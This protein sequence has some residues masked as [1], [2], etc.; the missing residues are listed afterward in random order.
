MA[1]PSKLKHRAEWAS[2][3]SAKLNADAPGS[4]R[5]VWAKRE[6]DNLQS[7]IAHLGS[8]DGG[9]WV[10]INGHH[11]FMRDGGGGTI[12]APK[13][14]ATAG[15]KKGDLVRFANPQDPAEA[16][17]VYVL[18]ELHADANPP[19][20]T[21]QW[22][23]PMSKGSRFNPIETVN[24]SDLVQANPRNHIDFPLYKHEF[25]PTRT[26]SKLVTRPMTDAERK[27]WLK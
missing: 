15:L 6:S 4:H 5:A 1:D 2:R 19:R 3:E 26:G 11:V 13:P 17:S 18:K 7:Q 21:I 12:G 23:N 10:T 9:H 20:A 22:V 25:V 16:K 27:R 8:S 14:N 24:P